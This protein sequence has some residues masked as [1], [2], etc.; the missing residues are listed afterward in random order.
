MPGMPPYEPYCDAET[1][2]QTHLD[3]DR[4]SA[5]DV[6]GLPEAQHLPLKHL[7][8]AVIIANCGQHRA[9]GRKGDCGEWSAI[10]IEPRQ[11]G[12]RMVEPRRLVLDP[13]TISR[14]LAAPA[15]WP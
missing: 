3:L 14:R 8:I 2:R 11:L 4:I 6:A 10:V 9:V 12:L 7:L 5:R 15:S 1:E 13:P